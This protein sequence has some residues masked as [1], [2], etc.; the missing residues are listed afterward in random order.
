MLIFILTLLLIFSLHSVKPKYII[1][2]HVLWLLFILGISITFYPMYSLYKDK[3]V[4]LSAAFTTIMLT[5]ILSCVAYIYQ[6]YKVKNRIGI[7][8][9]TFSWNNNGI[10][11]TNYL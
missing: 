6:I 11:T 9:F 5:I 7:I 8:N 4:I 1:S 3:S 10:I 2:K